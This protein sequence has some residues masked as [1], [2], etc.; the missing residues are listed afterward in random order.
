MTSVV[1]CSPAI[2]GSSI[3]KAESLGIRY[4]ASALEHAGIEAAIVDAHCWGVSTEDAIEQIVALEPSI[5]GLQ[6]I[7]HSQVEAGAKIAQAVRSVFPDCRIVAGGHVP[8]FSA[9]ELFQLHHFDYLIRGEG[10]E[11]FTELVGAILSDPKPGSLINVRNSVQLVDGVVVQQPMR[12][13]VHDLDTLPF[14]R[15]DRRDYSNDP[16]AS[17][18]AS[19]GCYARCEFCSVPQ[20]FMEAPG[21][22]LWRHRSIE[23]VVQEMSTLH[24]E[25]G[26]TLFS[27]LDDIFLARTPASQRSAIQ[28]AAL[29]KKKLPGVRFAI[30]CRTDAVTIEAFSALRD[31]GLERVFLGLEAG[32]DDDLAV[33][34]KWA[35]VD[36][37][38]KALKIL[39]EIGIQIAFGF[40]N[41]YPESTLDG[42]RANIQFLDR[43]G[44]A[45]PSALCTRLDAYPGT[46]IW[47]KMKDAG[48]LRGSALAPTY[49]FSEPLVER[50]YVHM[51]SV[52]ATRYIVETARKKAE[53]ALA[54]GARSQ[55]YADLYS[56]S[57]GRLSQITAH[58]ALG[59]INDLAAGNETVSA[60]SQETERLFGP[61]LEQFEKVIA[62]GQH[63]ELSP[64]AGEHESP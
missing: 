30:E 33:Y 60:T 63:I 43:V 31:A 36:D 16:H 51:R 7:F 18:I 45:Y 37:S 1:L 21:R 47:K 14:P 59:I 62:G 5:V 25:Y 15:R 6:F 54:R 41:F 4:L 48:R 3:R 32:N 26:V 38:L 61:V 12:P 29:L 20:F 39:R 8:T 19:R 10:E 64:F 34:N 22:S 27:F 9:S 50:A 17:I 44:L 40:I 49:D 2:A 35:T 11:A 57:C 24:A 13:L 58:V 56:A 46:P 52:F 55:A 42:L 53:F 23:N 28:F